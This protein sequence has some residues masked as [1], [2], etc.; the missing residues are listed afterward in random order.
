MIIGMPIT[1]NLQIEA[2]A[3]ATGLTVKQARAAI[4]AVVGVVTAGLLEEGRIVLDGLGIFETRRR[5]ARHIRN[6]ATGVMMDLPPSQVIKFKPAAQLRA[7]V[8]EKG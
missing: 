4:D 6:P 5:S 2:V 7:R 1:K 3:E 8:E